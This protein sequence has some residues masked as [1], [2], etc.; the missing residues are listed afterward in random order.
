MTDARSQ[1]RGRAATVAEWSRATGTGL[2]EATVVD[3]LE[4]L[5]AQ[6]WL[7]AAPPALT[8]AELDF[9]EQHGGVSD[10]R[11]ALLRTRL[12]GALGEDGAAGESLTVEQTARLLEVSPSRVRHRIMAG[13]IYAYPSTG[14][15]VARLVPGWQ[16]RDA[17]PA[18]HLAE[19]LNALPARFR[20]SDV[21]AF[22]LN[23][24]IDDAANGVAVP[25]LLWLHD[26]GDPAVAVALAASEA[27]LI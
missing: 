24:R 20:P 22:A 15:G 11:E 3:A 13:T 17:T 25:L 4:T 8:A 16:F 10:N 12:A 18:P 5:R 14:R 2:D 1:R 6:G 27:R 7:T 23:A 19:V 21:R 26:G 9:L